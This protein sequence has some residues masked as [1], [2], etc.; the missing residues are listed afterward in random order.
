MICTNCNQITKYNI[1]KLCYDCYSNNNVV[2]SFSNIKKYYKLSDEE[3]E[4]LQEIRRNKKPVKTRKYL[5]KEVEEYV[6]ILVR[7][8]PIDNV[9]KRAYIKHKEMQ[10][11]Q[12]IDREKIN[13]KEANIINI[14]LDL[15]KKINTQITLDHEKV[16][17]LIDECCRDNIP[18]YEAAQLVFQLVNKLHMQS[19][20]ENNLMNIIENLIKKSNSSI[21][22]E[23]KSLKY[24]I[25]LY[26]NGGKKSEFTNNI[27]KIIEK[28]QK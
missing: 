5:S 10:N 1:S 2:I 15:I 18:D 11:K 25:Y 17:N 9:K 28:S 4:K 26:F 20:E 21:T 6:E 23:D 14:S 22:I 3:I 16:I 19:I 13:D 7:D 27:K 24:Q 8:L 12:N